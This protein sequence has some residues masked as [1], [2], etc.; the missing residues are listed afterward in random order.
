MHF[1]KSTFNEY[2]YMFLYYDYLSQNGSN[3]IIKHQQDKQHEFV[4]NT[5][6]IRKLTKKFIW[7]D[8]I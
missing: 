1:L 8:N 7:H 3:F 5:L 6:W 4:K 2:K